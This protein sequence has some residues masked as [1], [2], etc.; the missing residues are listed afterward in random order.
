M[1]IS[2][3]IQVRCAASASE[4]LDA[5]GPEFVPKAI[6]C[7]QRLRAGESGF[8]VLQM[9]LE[10][11]PEASGAMI[12]GE[13][14]SPELLRAEQEGYLVLRKPLQPDELHAVLSRWL[15]PCIV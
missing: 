5:I 8:D 7:D 6:F 1:L 13:Y 3:G 2:W 15:S 14:N 4:A 10:R 11:C 12:S 9:L